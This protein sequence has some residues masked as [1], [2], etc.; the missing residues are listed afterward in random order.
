MIELD[1]SALHPTTA[2]CLTA[3]LTLGEPHS[4]RRV[5]DMG[6]GDGL[7]ALTS[8]SLWNAEVL[9]VDI[10]AEAVY[11]A[12]RQA[13]AHALAERVTALRC[14]GFS[15]PS[16]AA[17][18][19]YDLILCNLLAEPI[20]RM[21]PDFRAHLAPGG[22]CIVSGILTWLEAEVTH[23]AA[24]QGFSPRASFP[25]PPWQTLVLACGG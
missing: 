8:A 24:A 19:P 2:A 10:D 9:A 17:R 21:M 20:I 7:L 12:R 5:L 15:D 6:C 13:L 16:V 23:A 22:L 4:F 11:R 18:G 14:D 1:I 25:N 3:M